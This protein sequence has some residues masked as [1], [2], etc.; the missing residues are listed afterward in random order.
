MKPQRASDTATKECL[1]RTEERV[2]CRLTLV[3]R[4]FQ[5]VLFEHGLILWG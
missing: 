4:D 3:V 1:A 5:L 2:R